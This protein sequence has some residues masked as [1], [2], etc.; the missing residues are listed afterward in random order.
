[1]AFGSGDRGPRGERQQ[2]QINRQTGCVCSSVCVSAVL[3]DHEG[4][5]ST[6]QIMEDDGAIS[7]P[8]DSGDVFDAEPTPA[9]VD[10]EEQQAPADDMTAAG[11][12]E[13]GAAGQEG[14]REGKEGEEDGVLKDPPYEY[15]TGLV[16]VDDQ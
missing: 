11:G 7:S 8:K 12:E 15:P 10:S 3:V 14:A 1:M 4:N 13:E 16:E 6:S 9:V 5:T 2:E